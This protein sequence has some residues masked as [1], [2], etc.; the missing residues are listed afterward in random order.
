MDFSQLS[1][2]ARNFGSGTPAPQE[3]TSE[4]Q[5][6]TR[7]MNR[8]PTFSD[9]FNSNSLK[10]FSNYVQNN[11][12]T[13]LD[14]LGT[15]KGI[16]EEALG[17]HGLSGVG[18]LAGTFIGKGAKY[19]DQ[20][21]ERLASEMHAKG[22]TPEEI[23]KATGVRRWN[24]GARQEIADNTAK[25]KISK[26]NDPNLSH[27]RM[28][29]AGV[30][31]VPF[32][33]AVEIFNQGYGD[34]ITSVSWLP[35][36]IDH[37]E[38]FKNYPQLEKTKVTINSKFKRGEAQYNP[39]SNTINISDEDFYHQDLSPL[40]HEI[41]HNV[42]KIEGWQSGGSPEQFSVVDTL[43][44]HWNPKT[45]KLKT[46]NEFEQYQLLPGEVEARMT[47][48]RQHLSELERLMRMPVSDDVSMKDM[49][50]HLRNYGRSK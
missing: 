35:N 5:Q 49:L 40:L 42:Q 37:P 47:E 4:P 36:L 29:T 9:T 31:Q 33:K 44:P 38:L 13:Y 39:D 14:K 30:E 7:S 12:N 27:F 10:S 46:Y 41:Q 1:D 23:W 17:G 2:L 45:K 50:I 8:V 18:G 25:Y 15:R 34:H 19:F 3:Y 6:A 43:I 26:F 21:L 22:S 24:S 16:Q 48:K 28:S 20:S 32:E 11:A